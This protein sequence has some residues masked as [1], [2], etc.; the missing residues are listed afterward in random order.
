MPAVQKGTCVEQNRVEPKKG[1]VKYAFVRP[2]FFVLA[3][4]IFR[5]LC[6][7]ASPIKKYQMV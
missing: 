7:C 1:N 5:L 4:I 6:E 3:G 2:F